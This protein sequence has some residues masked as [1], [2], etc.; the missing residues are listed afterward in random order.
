MTS[1]LV[2]DAIALRDATAARAVETDG[3]HLVEIGH[4][5]VP[6]GDLGDLAQRRDVAVHGV[7]GLE[8]DDLRHARRILCEQLIQMRDI[9]VAEDALG[10]A[11]V[12]DALDHRGM[13]QRIGEDD[14]AR[15]QFRQRRE[16]RVVGDVA[17]CEEER[18]RLAMQVRK[19]GLE[20]DV[21]ARRAGDI[22][23][24]A[25]AGADRVDC[26]VHGGENGLVLAHAQIIVRTPHFDPALG[27]TA[28][29][30][31]M[32][33]LSAFALQIGEMP[34]TALLAKRLDRLGQHV[35]AVIG[36]RIEQ[37]RGLARVYL[38]GVR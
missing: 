26:R 13:V 38:C 23:R 31:R 25:G 27:V 24:A 11:A 3:M 30:E 32:R 4:G 29:R 10:S 6:A 15:Q 14:G 28:L 19:L 16:R 37:T 9:V 1:M 2:E 20:R 22:A 21:I 17:G 36:F 34:I 5:A 18:R 8:G 7:D 33:K 12:A 35:V